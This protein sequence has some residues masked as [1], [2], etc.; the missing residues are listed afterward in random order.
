MKLK[1]LAF[2]LAMWTV[3][4]WSG[5]G[6]IPVVSSQLTAQ[7]GAAGLSDDTAAKVKAAH[8][9]LKAAMDALQQD[10]KYEGVSDTPNAYLILSGGGNAM[11]D[12]QSGQGVDPESFAALYS[13]AVKPEILD[14]LTT[15]DQGR[16][17][18]NDQLVRLY[19]RSRLER[20]A[21]ERTKLSLGG[22]ESK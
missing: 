8:E 9:S 14:S 16:V 4:Y 18:Y 13:K 7:D 21:A 10:G 11:E 19:S 3:G 15:D 6:N 1:L 12:L 22:G 17:L 20:L 5:S 2:G